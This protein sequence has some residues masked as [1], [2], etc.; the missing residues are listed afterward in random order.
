M[1]RDGSE[2][3][4]SVWDCLWKWAPLGVSSSLRCISRA[5]GTN[6]KVVLVYAMLEYLTMDLPSLS[7]LYASSDKEST[8][9]GSTRHETMVEQM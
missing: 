1:A 7:D 3:R 4:I 2:R 8:G 6:G 5:G 9:D